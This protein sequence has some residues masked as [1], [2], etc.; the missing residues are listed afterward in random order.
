MLCHCVNELQ[1]LILSS[2]EFKFICDKTK[3]LICL[4]PQLH[5]QINR[6]RYDVCVWCG[7]EWSRVELNGMVLQVFICVLYIYMCVCVF[8]LQIRSTSTWHRHSSVHKRIEWNVKMFA[9]IICVNYV[10]LAQYLPWHWHIQQNKCSPFKQ[11]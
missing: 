5:S 9:S 7:G 4:L 2:Y 3:T 8:A 10:I 1:T 11:H 6:H